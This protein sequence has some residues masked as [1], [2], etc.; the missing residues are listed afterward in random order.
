MK[1]NFPKNLKSHGFTLIELLVV[2]LIIGILAAIALPQY[3]KAVEKSRAAEALTVLRS[4]KEAKEIYYLAN[5]SY[6][7]TLDDLDITIPESK[8]W[9]YSIGNSLSSSA[10]RINVP[11]DKQYL[12]AFR[13][14]EAMDT[15]TARAICR[16]D[17]N[18]EYGEKIC[19]TL[20]AK[21]KISI[22]GYENWTLP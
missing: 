18:K 13:S 14:N 3:T 7:A 15:G 20:G 12:I 2:V 6:P 17:S 19:K 16:S 22:D 10:T 4:I 5:N 8:I 21:E 1:Y 9:A 11:N